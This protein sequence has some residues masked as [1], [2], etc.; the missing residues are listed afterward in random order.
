MAASSSGATAPAAAA[1]APPHLQLTRIRTLMPNTIIH[2]QKSDTRGRPRESAR[3]EGGKWAPMAIR[4]SGKRCEALQMPPASNR[5]QLPS[6]VAGCRW[7]ARTAWAA[8]PAAAVVPAVPAQ[9][10]AHTSSSL[11]P[12]PTLACSV[13]QCHG[14][15][16][17]VGVRRGW[18][19]AHGRAAGRPCLEGQPPPCVSFAALQHNCTTAPRLHPEF[20]SH[21]CVCG[22]LLSSPQKVAAPHAAPRNWGRSELGRGYTCIRR[23]MGGGTR[24]PT[25]G[26]GG[27]LDGEASGTRRQ[28]LL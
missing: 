10:P 25:H 9:G 1:G 18:R 5:P 12:C 4:A 11:A 24:L 26:G 28:V 17:P 20:K 15:T 2:C 21:V 23:L 8:R 14:R 13:P 6:K 7:D 27:T 3:L 16:A 19:A 22:H